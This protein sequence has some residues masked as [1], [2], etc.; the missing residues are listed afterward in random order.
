VHLEF[1]HLQDTA[2]ATPCHDE[3]VKN[4]GSILG[5]VSFDLGLAFVVFHVIIGA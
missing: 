3:H 4:R 2:A 5:V 1:S